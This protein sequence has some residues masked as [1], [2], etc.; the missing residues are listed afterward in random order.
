MGGG[1]EVGLDRKMN[2]VEDHRD[3]A[4]G[5]KQ[6]QLEQRWRDLYPFDIWRGGM[7]SN[8]VGY[9]YAPL[10]I[11]PAAF[12]SSKFKVENVDAVESYRHDDIFIFG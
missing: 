8:F 10:I 12:K 7:D 4:S 1:I 11:S 6:N 3:M 5:L 9:T 2:L